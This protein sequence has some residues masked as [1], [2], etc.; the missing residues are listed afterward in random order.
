MILG[1]S[2]YQQLSGISCFIGQNVK[3]NL[4]RYELEE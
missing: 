1:H 3:Q 4:I 2:P